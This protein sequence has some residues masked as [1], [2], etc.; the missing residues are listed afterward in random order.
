MS[1]LSDT[2]ILP[3]S[4]AIEIARLACV[5]SNNQDFFCDCARGIVRCAWEQPGRNFR[6]S[7]VLNQ[8]ANATRRLR[9]ASHSF[10]KEDLDRISDVL[11]SEPT[12][13]KAEFDELRL[14]LWKLDFIFSTAIRRSMTTDE[15]LGRLGKRGAKKKSRVIGDPAL[16][17][18][19]EGLLLSAN[20]A[21]GD[22]TFDKNFPGGGTLIDALNV[23]KVYL[24]AGTIPNALPLSTIQRIK[25]NFSNRSH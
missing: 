10:S 19:V 13:L 3:R 4:E 14:T 2:K 7:R 18:I 25:T 23:L 12:N 1:V 6:P 8:A 11:K 15:C 22:L 16:H 17:Y 21:E 5:P 9:E 24:P 20:C